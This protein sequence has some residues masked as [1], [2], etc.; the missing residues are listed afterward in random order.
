MSKQT[1]TLDPATVL[2]S[3]LGSGTTVETQLQQLLL[4]DLLRQ[5]QE[6]QRAENEHLAA[7]KANMAELKKAELERTMS[8]DACIHRK[9]P[10]SHASA[11]AGQRTHRGTVVY[12]CQYCGKEFS[13]RTIPPD[14][15]VNPE[16]IGG[17]H[18]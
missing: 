16:I 15:R 6:R 10:P 17:P 12:M 3:G 5:K 9:P 8:Q 18:Q 11:L 4:E 1:Q 13:E 14:L 2:A 7:R